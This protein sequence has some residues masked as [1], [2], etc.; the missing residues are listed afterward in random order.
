MPN[1]ALEKQV[2]G[3]HYK[4][5]A[6][7]PAEYCQRNRLSYCESSVIQYVTRHREKNGRQ[8]IEK[9]IHCLELLLAIEY[10]PQPEEEVVLCVPRKAFARLPQGLDTA[11][12]TALVSVIGTPSNLV[13][14]ARSKAE[15]DANLKQLIPYIVIV[16][17]DKVLRYRRGKR[18]GEARL[19]G[20]LS[21]G[22]GGHIN[23]RSD[24]AYAAY[25]NGMMRELDEE[26]GGYGESGQS[27]QMPTMVAVLNDDS[28]PVGSVHLG[29]VH[30]LRV[31]SEDIVAKCTSIVDPEFVAFEQAV[32][33]GDQCE[34]WS[35][36]CLA[37]LGDLLAMLPSPV[38]A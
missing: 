11:I 36:L 33:E 2:G 16:C 12:V 19:H 21:I 38:R 6:I 20:K 8:D 29:I 18:G 37:R 9:A 24:N 32:A 30:V 26:L 5:L 15:E 7:Q 10:P 17:G 35:K 34:N 31:P 22:I 1:D 28:D 4:N 23:E 27:C 3:S 13:Y 14:V 25:A